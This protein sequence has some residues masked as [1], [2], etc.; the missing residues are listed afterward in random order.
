MPEVAAGSHGVGG[1]AC[2]RRRVGGVAGCSHTDAVGISSVSPS[3]GK[4]FHGRS[5]I[6]VYYF[7]P[8]SRLIGLWIRDT[9]R[10]LWQCCTG[11]PSGHSAPATKHSVPRD[12]SECP[13]RPRQLPVP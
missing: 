6:R 9:L 11:V 5:V 7:A 4:N 10:E 12:T 8:I 13:D 1:P 3:R 2:S